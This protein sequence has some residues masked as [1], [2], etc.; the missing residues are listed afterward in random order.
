MIDLLELQL[1]LDRWPDAEAIDR[2]ATFDGR[3]ASLLRDS[4]NGRC[5]QA[6][7]AVLTR[8]LVREWQESNGRIAL[9]AP[10]RVPHDSRWPSIAQWAASGVEAVASPEA[11]RLVAVHPWNPPWAATPIDRSLDAFAA[12]REQR[13]VNESV[14]ADPVWRHATG[15]S[16]YRSLEQREAVRTLLT[17]APD[18]TVLVLLP[19]GSGKSLV[20]LLAPL[21][22][23]PGSVTAV[24]VP[25]TSLAFDQEEQLRSRLRALNAPDAGLDF[26]FHGSLK[27]PERGAFLD[28]VR[29]GGQR[30]VFTSPEALFGALG[31]ALMHAASSGRLGQFVIDEAHIVSGWGADFRP[32]FQA[33]GGFR[34]SLRDAARAGQHT[35]RTVLMTATAAAPDVIALSQLFCD[36]GCPLVAGGAVALRP[37]LS[38]SVAK[39]ADSDERLARVGEALLHLPRPLFLYATERAHVDDLLAYSESLGLARTVHVTGESSEQVRRDA[40]RAL[41]GS[42]DSPP[43]ADLAIGTSA[44]G[45][46][47]DVGDVRAVVHACLPESV[48]RYYQ[49]VGRAGR[50]GKSAL[51]LMLWEPGDRAVAQRLSSQR[52]IGVPLATERWSAMRKP[53]LEDGIQWVDMRSL[54]IGLPEDSEANGHWNSRTLSSMAR[55]GLIRFAGARRNEDGS[56]SIGIETLRDD[57]D[58]VLPWR[59]F[60]E[61][62]RTTRIARRANLDLVTGIAQGGGVCGVLQDLYTVHQPTI[63]ATDLVVNHAC[64]G[65]SACAPPRP[66]PVPPMPLASRPRGSFPSRLDALVDASGVVFGVGDDVDSWP[67]DYARLI[68]AGATVGVRHVVS[69]QSVVEKREPRRALRR[70]VA[71]RGLDA[72][73]VTTVDPGDAVDSVAYVVDGPTM[74]LLSPEERRLDAFE[75]IAQLPKPSVLVVP[76]S[77]TSR[78]RSDMSVRD[79]HPGAMT[80]NQLERSLLSCPI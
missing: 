60:E 31:E 54:R 29:D 51:G 66:I 72:P 55:A 50:D 17:S 1:A 73:L 47:I 4:A 62:R 8:G 27:P 53:E 14:G 5:G 32:D 28:R 59:A 46:G 80:V 12:V 63:L 43:T 49:E 41:R 3:Y 23:G 69:T 15:F 37:E 35:F 36:P 26:A 11:I 16:E 21:V 70:L 71:S 45:L 78:E 22:A 44:F 56:A 76:G 67:R 10:L 74:L 68:E 19:T 52:L 38:F 39:C 30:V 9:L 7:I 77:H 61:M 13:R 6:D 20:G 58:S 42:I 75:L 40:V 2:L 64:G 79:M 48:D 18:A 24:V 57:L 33:L 34:A 25:T 65:C